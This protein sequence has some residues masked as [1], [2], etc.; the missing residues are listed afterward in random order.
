MYPQFAL[1]KKRRS[2]LL[3]SMIQTAESDCQLQSVLEIRLQISRFLHHE[4]N[5]QHGLYIIPY[6]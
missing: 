3:V 4:S 6:C 1:A 2:N 5:R